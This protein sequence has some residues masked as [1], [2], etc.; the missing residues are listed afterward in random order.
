MRLNL[1]FHS[2]FFSAR[3]DPVYTYNN[4]YQLALACP[5]AY[6]HLLS[7]EKSLMPIPHSGNRRQ[8]FLSNFFHSPMP[9]LK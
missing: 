1:P 6:L 9:A 4:P 8:V 3:A 5:S 7:V 2:S